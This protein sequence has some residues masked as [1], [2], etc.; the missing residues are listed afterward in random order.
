MKEQ[1]PWADY[2]PPSV[3]RKR[4]EALEADARE[5]EGQGGVCGRKK[6]KKQKKAGLTQEEKMALTKE[7]QERIEDQMLCRFVYALHDLEHCGVVRLKPG[8]KV[9]A[10]MMYS[11]LCE[12]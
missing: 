4:K 2:K 7:E 11:W 6:R 1:K 8:G 5:A 12:N 10:R 9:A 3:L